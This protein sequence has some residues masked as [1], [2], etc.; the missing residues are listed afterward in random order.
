MEG[1]ERFY[2][3][4]RLIFGPDVTSLPLTILLIAGPSVV[5]TC[6]VIAKIH[7]SEKIAHDEYADK[8]SKILGY[9]VLVFTIFLT[10]ADMIFL[11]L[12]SGRDPGIVPRSIRPLDPDENFDVATPS[13]EWVS[14]RTPNL[15]FPRTKDV[16]VN[17]F[18]VKVKYCDTCFLYRPPRAS[19]CSVCN[20]CV[21]KFDHHCP[22]VGQC[23]GLRNYRFFFMFISSATFLCIYIF[24][25]SLMNIFQERKFY[26]S[27]WRSM[28]AEVLS[29]V[30]IIYT[31]LAVWFVGG[32]TVFHLYL[33]ITNQT[34][35]ENF[36][37]HYDKKVN[38]Y[39]RGLFRNFIDIF[40]SRMP[41]SLND[42]RSSVLEDP[43]T[44]KSSTPKFSLNIINP[45]EKINV[46]IGNKLTFDNN[47]QIPSIL[48]DFDYGII[49]N[50][51]KD[52]NRTDNN[53]PDPFAL[54]VNQEPIF[55]EPIETEERSSEVLDLQEMPVCFDQDAELRRP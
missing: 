10:V 51:A 6:Q 30:L 52:K 35:Y 39:N 19:H 28:S 7:K 24:T 44:F 49:D 42:F 32:L 40:F 33:I 53:D 43:I 12:T 48:K 23:I 41:P 25:F 21:M 45:N 9:P 47:S 27:L 54:L 15:R 17:G 22:W 2:C 37:Y 3:G 55:D 31:F 1:K 50:D 5:F 29:L 26:S 36:R 34:T 11:L 18:I 4:G 13:M 8:H 38:P 16:T 46:D 20:N 14:G